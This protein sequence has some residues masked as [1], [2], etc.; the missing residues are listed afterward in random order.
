M[1]IFA[2]NTKDLCFVAQ[3]TLSDLVGSW[4]IQTLA[5]LKLLQNFLR[6]TK[7]EHLGR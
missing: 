6:A 3:L 2:D 7:G 5:R 4:H 1:T